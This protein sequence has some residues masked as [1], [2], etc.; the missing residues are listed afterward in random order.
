M[1]LSN[2]QEINDTKSQSTELQNVQIVFEENDDKPGSTNI[3]LNDLK[4]IKVSS[5]LNENIYNAFLILNYR[6]D[7]NLRN[8]DIHNYSLNLKCS[9]GIVSYVIFIVQWSA[10]ILLMRIIM[11][12]SGKSYTDWGNS[13]N[14]N[15]YT[16]FP[17]L[18]FGIIATAKEL[19]Q[20]VHDIMLLKELQIGVEKG[21]IQRIILKYFGEVAL[22]FFGGLIYFSILTVYSNTE[23]WQDTLNAI[24]NILAYQFILDA[25]EWAYHYFAKWR[26]E[27]YVS[28]ASVDGNPIDI[29][30]SYFSIE[31]KPSFKEA[32]KIYVN[33]IAVFCY[34]TI[35]QGVL[36]HNKVMMIIAAVILI[37]TVGI[38]DI[39][40]FVHKRKAKQNKEQ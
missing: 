16:V 15:S 26:L 37:I 31:Q 7:L 11:L 22:G 8:I 18:T 23:Q 19:A 1:A 6:K 3:V 9:L 30:Q 20:C 5:K 10:L 28:R 32:T 38:N 24:L 29:F 40:T 33:I 2:D 17:F 12:S 13:S 25:D 27:K 4:K 21:K 39:A 35:F 34:C 36:S 14:Y